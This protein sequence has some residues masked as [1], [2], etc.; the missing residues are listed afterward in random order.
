MKNIYIGLIL[1]ALFTSSCEDF[2]TTEPINK[3]AIEQYINDEGGLTQALAGVYDPLGSEAIY[4]NNLYTT[5]EACT[6]E[7]YYARSAQVLGVQVYNFDPTSAEVTNLWTQLYLGINRANDLIAHINV[8]KMDEA[9]R[10]EILGEALFLR[11]YYYF[12]LVTRFGDVPLKLT[13]TTSPNEVQVPRSTT[14]DVYAQILKD[15]KEAEGKVSQ[16]RLQFSTRVS[17][18]V[19][20]GILARVCLQ[21]AGYPLMDTSKYADA[22]L[23]SSKVINSGDGYALNETFKTENGGNATYYNVTNPTNGKVTNNAYRQIFINESEDIEDSKECMWEISFKGNRTDSYSEAGR[24]GNTNGITMAP[25]SGSSPLIA[26]L[27]YSYG[28]I[29]GTGRL[30][31]K[32]DTSG[33]D[34]RRDWVLTTYTFTVNNSTNT[35]TKTNITGTG[36]N[37]VKFGRDCGKW[38]REY[39]TLQPKNKNYTPLNF[40]VLRYA[41][42]LLMF[43]EAELNVNGPTPAAL[44][45]INQVRRRGY[46]LPVNTPSTVSDLV[47]LTQ[48]DIEDERMRELC[49]EGLRRSDLIRWGKFVTTMNSVGAEM[50]AATNPNGTANNQ[51][52]GGR[53]G[54]NVT[55]KHLLFP[56]PSLEL[57]SN[58]AL[59]QNEN[60]LN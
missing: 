22:L 16:T 2:L 21:M 33:K 6:D 11:G 18:G 46:G 12:M 14:A 52:Y 38:R 54:K 35:V 24:L 36:V 4:G 57:L 34:L 55:L 39:E 29:K 25:S 10:Q 26:N 1:V 28:F 19:V 30:F 43:A 9:K 53:G 37:T 8:P 42:V 51:Q 56:I 47:T 7:G 5:L 41:D 3:I 31:N 60:W 15:M 50:A 13:P 58:K 20:Q 44:N 27:G 49:F 40:P 45:A 23:W 59:T 32:Y 17:R 48:Q